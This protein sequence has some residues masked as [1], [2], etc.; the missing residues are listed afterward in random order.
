M[1]SETSPSEY[2]VAV[3]IHA[4]VQAAYA[5]EAELIGCADFP[6]LKISIQELQTSSDT[7]LG[8]N[9]SGILVAVL[10]FN[11][12]SN[13]AVITRL[14]V[15]PA[16]FRQGIATAL[17]SEFERRVPHGRVLTVST[18]TANAP[19]VSLYQSLKYVATYLSCSPQGIS[20]VHFSKCNAVN[21][22][23]TSSPICSV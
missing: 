23:I 13:S 16:H 17:V 1:I 21:G 18:A 20:L 4:V 12:Q 11:E 10:S 8:F 6:P 14:I 15:S 5:I 9:I 2:A 3:Q 22:P 7:F 19:A